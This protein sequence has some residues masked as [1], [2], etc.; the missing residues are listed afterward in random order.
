MDA[1]PKIAK[2]RQSCNS[3]FVCIIAIDYFCLHYCNWQPFLTNI[4]Q[5]IQYYIF[6]EYDY[7]NRCVITDNIRIIEIEYVLKYRL[8]F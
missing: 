6:N 4:A 1:N 3:F 8:D 2:L 7:I 5:C